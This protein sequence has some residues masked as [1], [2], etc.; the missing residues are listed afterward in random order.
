MLVSSIPKQI[1]QGDSA[2]WDDASFVDQ[3]GLSY[4]SLSYTLK[5]AIS[6]P[7][8]NPLILTATAA[9]NQ[10]GWTTALTTVQSAALIPGTYWWQMQVFATG[11]R[12]TVARGELT[13]SPDLGAIGGIYD[14]RTQAEVALAQALAAY[15]SFSASNGAVKAYTIGN[16][17]MTFQDLAHIQLQVNYWRAR[18]VTEKSVAGGARDRHLHIRFDG[19]S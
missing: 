16:R 9:A 4:S 1:L 12:N 13:V 6:G 18:V 7:I 8:P 14:G 2:T 15:A 17:S 11:V 3:N 5:Y 10:Q 19:I